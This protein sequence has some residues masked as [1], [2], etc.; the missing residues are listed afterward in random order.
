MMYEGSNNHGVNGH[1]ITLH[2][3]L[4]VYTTIENYPSLEETYERI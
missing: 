4:D 1:N 2:I 3:T